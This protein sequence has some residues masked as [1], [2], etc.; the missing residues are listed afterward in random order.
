MEKQE[1]MSLTEAR[2]EAAKLSKSSG[3]VQYILVD[4][5]G[6]CHIST[7]SDKSVFAAFRNGSEFSL[8]LDG[9]EPEPQVKKEKTSTK[10]VKPIV[11]EQDS[12]EA[13]LETEPKSASTKISNKTKMSKTKTKPAAKKTAT[14]AKSSTPKKVATELVEI[15]ASSVAEAVKQATKEGIKKAKVIVKGKEY[16]LRNSSGWA[17][18]KSI[19]ELGKDGFIM[20]ING[21]GFYCYPKADYKQLFGKIFASTTYK[22][23][24]IYSQSN[25]PKWHEE[26]FTAS[27]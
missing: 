6:D 16:G 12:V 13:L 23:I 17:V 4:S 15:K 26:Y 14:P 5:E 10:K 3:K 19:L 21:Q 20:V 24:G 1:G 9:V 18:V 7:K 25:L 22:N 11:E 2:V 27:K 8:G